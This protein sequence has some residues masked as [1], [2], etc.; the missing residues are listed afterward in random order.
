M[1]WLK[2]KILHAFLLILLS[3]FL[4]IMTFGDDIGLQEIRKI[5]TNMSTDIKTDQV[6]KSPVEGWYII[7]KGALYRIYF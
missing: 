1:E 4:P 7:K 3:I 5:V 2:H 6:L